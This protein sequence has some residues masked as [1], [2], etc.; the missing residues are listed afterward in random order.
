MNQ[1]AKS[2]DH[3]QK[4]PLTLKLFI[5]HLRFAHNDSHPLYNLKLP[6]SKTTVAIVQV[7]PKPICQE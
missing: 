4:V 2:V 3:L 6:E 1:R 5:A 7:L